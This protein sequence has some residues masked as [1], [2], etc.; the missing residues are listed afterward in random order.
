MKKIILDCS[1]GM[2]IFVDR[3]G[4]IFSFVDKE[5]KRHTDNLLFKLDELLNEAGINVSEIDVFCVCIGPGSFTGIRVAVSI[6][7]GLAINS[8]AKICVASNFD[9]VFNRDIKNC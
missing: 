5:Q 1:E 7:K 3:D 6:V 4:K 2:S 9:I 8:N